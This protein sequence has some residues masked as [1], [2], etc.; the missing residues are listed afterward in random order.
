MSS[1][2]CRE[3]SKVSQKSSLD[4][5]SDTKLDGWR[6]R[7]KTDQR[8]QSNG[9]RVTAPCSSPGTMSSMPSP[10]RV[11]SRRPS[12]TSTPSSS[13]TGT[14][15]LLPPTL[16]RAQPSLSSLSVYASSH[17]PSRATSPARAE[18]TLRVQNDAGIL[19]AADDDE[20]VEED[21]APALGRVEAPAAADERAKR[22]LREQL[23]QTLSTRKPGGGECDY[24]TARRSA[25]T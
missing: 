1:V 7:M 18:A 3:R 24:E 25:L 12:G 21:D 5:K 6:L 9:P 15:G 14:H 22:A 16:L 10:S 11:P 19:L 17:R 13:S 2:R 23:R 20:R 8:M 4:L